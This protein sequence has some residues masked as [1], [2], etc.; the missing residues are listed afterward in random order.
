MLYDRP[1][2]PGPQPPRFRGRSETDAPR[3]WGPGARRPQGYRPR[4]PPPRGLRGLGPRA[5]HRAT[6]KLGA[7]RPE[8][9]SEPRLSPPHMPGGHGK[10]ELRTALRRPLHGNRPAVRLDQPL[11]D[12]EAEPGTTAALGPP[13]LPEDPRHKFRRDTVALV[14][15]GDRDALGPRPDGTGAR[16]Y[17]R[18]YHDSHGTSAVPYGVLNKVSEDT[19]RPCPH[20]AMSRAARRRSPPGT[21]RPGRR[22]PPAR[23]RFSPPDPGR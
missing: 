10:S 8:R 3:P 22:P 14:P 1:V 2:L 21:G 13:E 15:D 4:Q 16:G 5:E 17:Q 11:D 20:R 7:S 19:G 9:R 23:R 12:V 18:L 6:A